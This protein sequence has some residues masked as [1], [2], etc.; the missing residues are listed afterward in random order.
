[1]AGLARWLGRLLVQ[2]TFDLLP[3]PAEVPAIEGHRDAVPESSPCRTLRPRLRGAYALG[4]AFAIET[5]PDRWNR[6][7]QVRA[8]VRGHLIEEDVPQFAEEELEEFAR[9]NVP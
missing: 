6:C 1:M 2:F 9:W 8:T 3:Q 7:H 4:Q 5:G